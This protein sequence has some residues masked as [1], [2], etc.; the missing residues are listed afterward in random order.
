[1]VGNFFQTYH[2]KAVELI[3]SLIIA[4]FI[5]AYLFAAKTYNQKAWP[6]YRSIVWITGMLCIFVSIV[7]PIASL[8]HHIF[9]F[10]MLMHLLLGMLAPLLIALSKPI[11]L[12]YKSLKVQHAR[13]ISRLLRSTPIQIFANPFIALLLNIGGLWLLYT[14]N[15]FNLMHESRLFF[16]LLHIH[17]FIAGYIFTTSIIANEPLSHK[18][19]YFFRSF[20]LII[21][22]AGHD[23][24]AKFL[25]SN[26]LDNFTIHDV[27][28]GAVLMYYVGDF[29]DLIIIT[30]LCF[31][32]YNATATC[33]RKAF[34]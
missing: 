31:N 28:L 18:Y 5:A 4:L 3:I 20:I 19:S 33:K 23:I 24:L 13:R 8:S 29:I 6:T 9:V 2:F 30:L 12:L 14:T 15:F 7:G 34:N 16:I 21:A 10:H 27:Q 26:Q 1:M 25:F 11:T 17:L 32:W 22:I